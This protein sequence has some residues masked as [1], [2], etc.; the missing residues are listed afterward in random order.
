MQLLREHLTGGKK[1][2]GTVSA[3]PPGNGT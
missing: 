3:E 2:S 1:G